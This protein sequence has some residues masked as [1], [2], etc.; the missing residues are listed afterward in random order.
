MRMSSS[1]TYELYEL[2]GGL[3]SRS[4]KTASCGS[5]YGRGACVPYMA[6]ICTGIPL[7]GA[8][9]EAR[10]GARASAPAASV[11]TPSATTARRVIISAGFSSIHTTTL[12]LGSPAGG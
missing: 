6:T 2:S 11:P 4:V 3:L 7:A 8:C 10:R 12:E 5:M 9:A 1:F